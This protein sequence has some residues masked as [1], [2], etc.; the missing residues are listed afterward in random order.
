MFVALGLAA[1]GYAVRPV[2]P[3]QQSRLVLPAILIL[4]DLFYVASRDS[5][6]L[7]A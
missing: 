6:A 7:C 5:L 4:M 2:L 1:I 3:Q